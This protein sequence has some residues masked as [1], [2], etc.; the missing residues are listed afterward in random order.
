MLVVGSMGEAEFKQVN[1]ANSFPNSHVGEALP[2]V[3]TGLFGGRCRVNLEDRSIMA[4]LVGGV[5]TIAYKG[6]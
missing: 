4:C 2:T 1:Q 5:P 6:N 3:V